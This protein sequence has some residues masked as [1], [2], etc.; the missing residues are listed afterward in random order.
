MFDK[1]W[2]GLDWVLSQYF[3]LNMFEERRS[4]TQK[5][6]PYVRS[7]LNN[8]YDDDDDD[9]DDDDYNDDYDDDDDED[10]A[11]WQSSGQENGSHGSHQDRDRSLPEMAQ[12][13]IW[14]GYG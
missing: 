11:P 5:L 13:G 1:I 9:D 6:A 8:K 12:I 7:L 10:E 4:N 3:N 2:L 14:I